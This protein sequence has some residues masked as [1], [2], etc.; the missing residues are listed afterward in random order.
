MGKIIAIANQK[1]GVGKTTTSVNLSACLAHLGKKVLLI[2]SD[3]QG[4]ATSGVGVNKGDVQDC[5]YNMLIDDVPVRDVILPTE[6]ENLEI[7]PATISL[8]G[9]EIELVSTISREVRMKH[10]IQDIKDDYDYVIID[11]PPSLGLLTLN[12]L[13][14]SDSI[15]IPVQCEYYA[16]EGLSQLLSTIRLVQKHLN[17]S[18]YIDGVLLTM[19]DAR[20]NLGIQVIE[21]VKKY[22]QDKVYK[23]IIPRNVRLS[24]APSH[25]KPIILYDPRSKGAEVYSELAKEVVENE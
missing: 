6:I 9:A 23:T 22:F 1:G 4:N 10:A 16:L 13:T 19:F 2:D 20:T 12:A 7:V 15:I 8:A 25:G 17:E 18:L 11:C 24:E 14:A 5:I 3:P 21:E